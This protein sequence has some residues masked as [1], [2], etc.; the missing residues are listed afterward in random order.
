[1]KILWENHL[2]KDP[3]RYAR[4]VL[5]ECGLRHPPICEK[6]VAD[7]LGLEIEEF[8][9]DGISQSEGI[10]GFL[11]ATDAWLEH[12]PNGKSCIWVYRDA[13]SERKRLGV[14]HECSHGIL[15]WHENLNYLCS[16]KDIGPTAHK[17]TEQEAF[18]CGAEF[19]MPREMLVED[20]VSLE[21]GISAIEQFHSRY[22]ASMEATAIKYAYT[23]P[24][25]CGIVMVE[26]VENQKPEAIP[27]DDTSRGRLFLPFEPPPQRIFLGE[28]KEYP[29]RV[30][31]SVK[32]HRFPKFIRPGTG[33]EEGNLVFE[34]WDSW[35]PMQ[36]EIPASV[37][38]SSAKLAYN[39][40]CLPLGN[41]GKLLVLL[42]LPDRY[43]KLNF[44][45]G[46]I[47]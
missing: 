23:H 2:G 9:L 27:K 10:P 44:K 33:I 45:N 47:L 31:Y 8:S 3:T 29:I 18:R 39:A 17:R 41:T 7:C 34:A 38:R 16:E 11:K 40:E 26:K 15:P 35:R 20:I 5:K 32:S 14:F 36:G 19:L 1:M 43:L 37:F 25:L 46:V 22:V 28:D 24:G 21:T 13:R 42:W 30:K 12:K 4:K 6:T